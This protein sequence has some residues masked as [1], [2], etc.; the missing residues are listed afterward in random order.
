[1]N[2]NIKTDFPEQFV[3]G[4]DFVDA[5]GN[6]IT[7]SDVNLKRETVRINGITSPEDAKR[8]VNAKLFTTFEKTRESCQ[9]DEGQFFWFDIIGCS[10]IEDGRELGVVKEI[11]RMAATDYLS[12]ITESSLVARGMAKS[13]LIPYHAP[14]IIQSDI[15]RKEIEVSGAFD[16]L[17]AS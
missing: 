16:L 17:E 4:A 3:V 14:F 7:L 10:V 6:T 15:E 12:V 13:F 9:L 5:K 8:F 2:L 11:E 1:M